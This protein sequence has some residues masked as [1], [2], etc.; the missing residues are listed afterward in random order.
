MINIVFIIYFTVISSGR[1]KSKFRP[2]DNQGCFDEFP[3]CEAHVAKYRCE[4]KEEGVKETEEEAGIEVLNAVE[5]LAFCRESCKRIYQNASQLPPNIELL[6]GVGDELQDVF[7]FWIPVCSLQKGFNSYYRRRL[8]EGNLISKTRPIKLPAFTKT[9]FKTVKIPK[10]IYQILLTHRKHALLDKKMKAEVTISGAVNCVRFEE[11]FEEK[12]CVENHQGTT[13]LME[14]SETS[15]KEISE[16][17]NPIA[18][19]WAGVPLEPTAVYGIRRYKRGAVLYAHLDKLSTHVI[20]VII[21]VAQKVN[22]PWPLYIMDHDGETHHVTLAPGEMLWYESAKLTHA[23]PLPLN[24]S[25]YDNIFVHFKPVSEKW[26]T[27]EDSVNGVPT[28]SL[29]ITELK[30][31]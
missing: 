21:N 14:M 13:Y 12:E 7:G 8:I 23:R 28:R 31:D 11:N 10:E 26:F 25:Y 29:T 18:E 4:G 20:S 9:G 15:Q 16:I 6:G 17:L 2:L 1:Q 24:G 22:E 27:D 5:A 19:K 3:E 30:E